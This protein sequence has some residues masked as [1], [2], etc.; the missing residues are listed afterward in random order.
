MFSTELRRR[1]KIALKSGV[2][3]DEVD[4]LIGGNPFATRWYVDSVNGSDSYGG[5]SAD[6]AFATM[7]KAFTK[8]ASFDE[9]YVRNGIYENLSTP[10]GVNDVTIVGCG[11]KPRHDNLTD[12]SKKG[13]AAW[14]TG[15]GVTDKPLLIVRTQGWRIV[16][17]L[18]A[19]PSAEACIQ[20]LRDTTYDASHFS[21]IGCRFAG[22]K[23]GIT[24][25]GGAGFVGLYDNIFQTQTTASI[26]CL[27]TA[28]AVPL[29]WD[30]QG[31]EFLYGSASHILSSASNWTIKDNVFALV[32]STA[33][34]IDLTHNSGQG[35]SNMVTG[36]TLAGVYTTADY[37]GSATD[38]WL[39]NWVTVVSTQAP[40]GFT[41][42]IAAA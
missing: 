39:G 27:S 37:V 22:G 12:A 34:Y 6:N 13:A 42:T 33:K 38:L 20:L 8:V 26:E 36:N 1:M 16:N 19:G 18:L 28:I 30:I 9:I 31:N 4:G 40:N 10:A 23:Y 41:I 2:L 21:A 24:N 15:T 17:M 3:A 7:T 11:N 14:R 32:A 35:L 5:R 29:I 25:N